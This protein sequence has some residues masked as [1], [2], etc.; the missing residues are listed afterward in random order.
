[1]RELQRLCL[2]CGHKQECAYHLAQGTAFEHYE[3][4]CPNSYT[5]N[6]IVRTRDAAP[7]YDSSNKTV[8]K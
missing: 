7:G 4:F 5:L 1:M 2:T 3:E 6:D 8:D